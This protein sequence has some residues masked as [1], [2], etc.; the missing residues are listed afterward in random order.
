[1]VAIGVGGAMLATSTTTTPH[2]Q[3]SP[4]SEVCSGGAYGTPAHGDSVAGHASVLQS[5]AAS[6]VAIKPETGAAQSGVVPS[7][8]SLRAPHYIRA[9]HS[10]GAVP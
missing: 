9:E 7:T 6:P 10:Y 8:G 3:P 1:V 2:A 4:C 5:E